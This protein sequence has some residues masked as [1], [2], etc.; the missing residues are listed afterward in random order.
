MVEKWTFH[1]T[2]KE[3]PL[4]NKSSD[5]ISDNNSSA[6]NSNLQNSIKNVK[7]A[8]EDQKSSTIDQTDVAR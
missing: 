3:L 5:S 2:S 7:F 1:D 4:E 8:D 6:I